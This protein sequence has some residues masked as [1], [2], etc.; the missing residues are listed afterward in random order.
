MNRHY[1]RVIALQILY[2]C[3]FRKAESFEEILKRHISNLGLGSEES[4]FIEELVENTFTN[5]KEIDRSIESV[6]PDWP[7]DQ[8]AIIDRNIL[9]MSICELEKL[10]TPP[11]VTIN[12]AIELAKTFGGETSSKFVNGVLGT[13]Y[14]KSNK[15]KEDDEKRD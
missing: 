2:E 12:E 8:V 9:R 15:Y 6:A 11:K 3:D 5:T 1:A 14:R 4:V 13:V 10:D 7:I